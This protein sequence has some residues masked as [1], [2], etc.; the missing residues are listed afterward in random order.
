MINEEYYKLIR[1]EFLSCTERAIERTTYSIQNPEKKGALK[2]FHSKLLIKE[3]IIWSQFERSYSTSFG[4]GLIE[5][6][7]KLIA[8]A[9][10]AEEAEG[11]K[12]TTV[13]LFENQFLKI[14]N[15]LKDLR[16]KNSGVKGNWAVDIA[17]ISSVQGEGSIKTERVISDLWFK[18]DGVEN[19]VSIKTVKPNIDQTEKAKKDL[20]LLKL[21]DSTCNVYFGLYYNPFGDKKDLYKPQAAGKI[22]DFLKDEVVLI[23]RDYWETIGGDGA[24]DN[25]LEI[26]GDSQVESVEMINEFAVVHGLETIEV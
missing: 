16:N 21:N 22:F 25:I 19:F 13:E 8:E 3:A 5:K 18:K 7:S 23:G 9:Y 10:G 20:L 12:E 17:N 14:E 15:H 24:Y 6:V 2:P 26:A 4:Q 11:Q 1:D